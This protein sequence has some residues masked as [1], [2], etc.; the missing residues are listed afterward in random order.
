[1]NM[2]KDNNNQLLKEIEK[3]KKKM[4]KEREKYSFK[5]Y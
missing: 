4:W 1:V 5:Y 3:L 2:L